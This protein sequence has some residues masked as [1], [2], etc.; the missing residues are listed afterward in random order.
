MKE[1]RGGRP[2]CSGQQRGRMGASNP[3]AEGGWTCSGGQQGGEGG[4]ER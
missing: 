2:T 3:G 4:D 1:G